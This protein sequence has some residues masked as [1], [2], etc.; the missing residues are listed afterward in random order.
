MLHLAYRLDVFASVQLLT[1][2][3]S[4]AFESNVKNRKTGKDWTH[5]I[6]PI[7]VKSPRVEWRLVIEET[8][9]SFGEEDRQGSG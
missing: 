7:H 3:A 6:L 1:K 4:S 5:T 8:D 2:R 9:V